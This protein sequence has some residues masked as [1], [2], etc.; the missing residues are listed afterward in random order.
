MFNRPKNL[1]GPCFNCAGRRPSPEFPDAPNCHTACDKYA[2]FRETLNA[3]KREIDERR[4]KVGKKSYF[5]RAYS[6]V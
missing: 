5:R 2:E 6:E 4:R 3:S 1:N